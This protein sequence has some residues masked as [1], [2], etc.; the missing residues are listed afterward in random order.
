MKATKTFSRQGLVYRA[1][2]EV[3]LPEPVLIKLVAE[4]WVEEDAPVQRVESLPVV[5]EIK[6]NVAKP[7]R[8]RSKK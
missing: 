2:E 8:K 3:D 1:G 6:T 4:G 5:A 7:A